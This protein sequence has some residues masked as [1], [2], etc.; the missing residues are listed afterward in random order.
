MSFTCTSTWNLEKRQGQH[1]GGTE[2]GN[3][4]KVHIQLVHS[5]LFCTLCSSGTPFIPTPSGYP[6]LQQ[7]ANVPSTQSGF[8]GLV[9]R[10][11]GLCIGS[12]LLTG[13][14]MEGLPC[15]ALFKIS[16]K[17]TEGMGE[18]SP[19]RARSGWGSRWTVW[20]NWARLLDESST[21][22]A[23]ELSA[24][25]AAVDEKPNSPIC[26]WWLSELSVCGE[27]DAKAIAFTSCTLNGSLDF[28]RLPN[29]VVS[30]ALLAL[31]L[32]LENVRSPG[33]EL[34]TR[35]PP[36]M[37]LPG[38]FQSSCPTSELESSGWIEFQS[39]ARQSVK[40]TEKRQ[41]KER[42]HMLSFHKICKSRKGEGYRDEYY[43][44][45]L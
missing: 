15:I 39:C 22:P 4:G 25:D 40:M 30:S 24:A 1:Q 13:S 31:G 17:G 11:S 19:M 18:S 27:F 35:N 44:Y 7:N 9:N 32:S 2:A 26:C 5:L 6:K 42:Q 23:S 45:L 10:S 37:V 8:S 3:L 20:S 14:F 16:R 41:K 28:R 36:A 12:I 43:H 34:S 21:R 33:W 29:P 38:R